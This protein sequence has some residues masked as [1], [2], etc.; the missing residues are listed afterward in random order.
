MAKSNQKEKKSSKQNNSIEAYDKSKDNKK[1]KN[2]STM[3][4]GHNSKSVNFL[5]L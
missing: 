1:T 5:S 4:H 2:K 3:K